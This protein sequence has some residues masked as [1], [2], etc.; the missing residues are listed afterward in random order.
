MCFHERK[1]G[2]CLV[3]VTVEKTD[4]QLRNIGSKLTKIKPLSYRRFARRCEVDIEDEIW[5]DCQ[6][7]C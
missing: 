5:G 1:I 2:L 6:S 3:C 7:R 4:D